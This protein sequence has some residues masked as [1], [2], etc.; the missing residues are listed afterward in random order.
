MF[1]K[2]KWLGVNR[3]AQFVF[4]TI[5]VKRQKTKFNFKILK[6]IISKNQKDE[7]ISK[8]CI[9]LLKNLAKKI[10]ALKYRKIFLFI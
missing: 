10:F 9:R 3:Q 2:N 1:C 4:D 5:E 8:I 6:N 7:H